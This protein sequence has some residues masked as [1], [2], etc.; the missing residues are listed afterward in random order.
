M[1]VNG[2]QFL[3]QL[4]VNGLGGTVVIILFQIDP[5]KV[6]GREDRVNLLHLGPGYKIDAPY[7]FIFMAWIEP[8]V[9]A[10]IDI[11]FKFVVIFFRNPAE[12]NLDKTV[13]Y[14]F[15]HIFRQI[16]EGG[17]TV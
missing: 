12:T 7:I 14:Q 1:L 6:H 5:F 15:I 11:L 17:D 13:V 9:H 3:L 16:Q 10:V 4:P 2:F 8:G